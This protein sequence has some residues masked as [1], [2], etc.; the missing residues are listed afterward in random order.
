M[1]N[2]VQCQLIRKERLAKVVGSL[3]ALGVVRG[4]RVPLRMLMSLCPATPS[5]CRKNSTNFA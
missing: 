1:H 4:A 2:L 3:S 5:S